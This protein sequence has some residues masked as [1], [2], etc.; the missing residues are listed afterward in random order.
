[1]KLSRE[2]RFAH[3]GPKM[4]V[5]RAALTPGLCFGS[6]L[7]TAERTDAGEKDN[8]LFTQRVRASRKKIFTRNHK[9]DGHIGRHPT[10]PE[11]ELIFRRLSRG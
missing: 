6:P 3:L 2:E 10:L 11:M 9:S 8:L 4:R 7:S 5:L 1:M